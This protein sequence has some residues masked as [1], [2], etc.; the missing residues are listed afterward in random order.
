MIILKIFNILS[1][2]KKIFLFICILCLTSCNAHLNKNNK[3]YKSNYLNDLSEENLISKANFYLKNKK[4]NNATEILESIRSIYKFSDSSEWAML[5]LIDIYYKNKKYDELIFVSEQF[6]EEANYQNPNLEYIAFLYADIHFK[7]AQ[8]EFKNI[9]DSIDAS[10]ALRWFLENFPNAD[11]K[12][13]KIISDELKIIN[14]S[15]IFNE[16][17]IGYFYEKRGNFL[18]A[19]KRYLNL[20]NNELSREGLYFEEILYRISYCYFHIGLIDEGDF[21]YDELTKSYPNTKFA[22]LAYELRQSFK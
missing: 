7:K 15:I 11:K 1:E 2:Y 19:L 5:K 6:I 13:L 18:A 8:N 12:Y 17:E 16:L 22:K 14:S 10:T 3:I 21:F 20:Y 4:L 9:N